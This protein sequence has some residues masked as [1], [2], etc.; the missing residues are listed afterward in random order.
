[1]DYNR[2]V[3]DLNGQTREGFLKNA[4]KIFDVQP[5]NAAYHPQKKGTFGMYFSGQWYHLTANSSAME[6]GYM[7]KATASFCCVSFT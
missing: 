1:M 5:V 7:E 6:V 2:V 3:L 4:A